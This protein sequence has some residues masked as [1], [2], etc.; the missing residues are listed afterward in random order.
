MNNVYQ[1]V[2]SRQKIPSLWLHSFRKLHSMGAIW[3]GKG[4]RLSLCRCEFLQMNRR[5][6]EIYYEYR[7][8]TICVKRINVV[9]DSGSFQRAEHTHGYLSFWNKKRFYHLNF[10]EIR[11]KQEPLTNI[12]KK[13][14]CWLAIAV[15]L[16]WLSRSAMGLSSCH[17]WCIAESKVHCTRRN[18][19]PFYHQHGYFANRFVDCLLPALS[20]LDK[21][22][23]L[24]SLQVRE[25]HLQH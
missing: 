1:V 8:R 23:Q 13:V 24:N 11:T 4:S 14:S 6:W 16:R 12:E 17:R 21:N 20:S 25:L 22:V 9:I 18:R 19:T 5:W 15:R 3:I 10:L 7:E 2:S